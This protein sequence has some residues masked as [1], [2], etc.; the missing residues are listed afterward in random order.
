MSTARGDATTGANISLTARYLPQPV[1]D[2]KGRTVRFLDD[3]IA[4]FILIAALLVGSIWF[5]QQ[6][7]TASGGCLTDPASMDF[8]AELDVAMTVTG[9][10]GC[11]IWARVSNTFVDSLDIEAAPRHGTLRRR[12]LS[13]VIYRP[14][15]GYVGDDAFAFVRRESSRGRDGDSFVRVYVHVK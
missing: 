3:N 10:A 8:A 11:A 12:G 13:G 5:G 14:E 7:R 4:I 6:S 15:P 1:P 9:G 2:A